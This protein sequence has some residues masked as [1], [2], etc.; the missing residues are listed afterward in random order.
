M[1][2][3]A[4]AEGGSGA[5]ELPLWGCRP[6]MGGSPDLISGPASPAGYKGDPPEQALAGS[7]CKSLAAPSESWGTKSCESGPSLPTRL[8]KGPQFHGE[9]R[10]ECPQGRPPLAVMVRGR[11]PASGRALGVPARKNQAVPDL[12]T[13]IYSAVMSI[14]RETECC[15]GEVGLSAGVRGFVVGGRSEGETIANFS[16]SF[17][18]PARSARRGGE[19][20]RRRRSE[21]EIIAKFSRGFPAPARAV[22][23][24]PGS[25]GVGGGNSVIF[26]LEGGNSRRF[27]SGVCGAPGGATG[28][29]VEGEPS[30]GGDVIVEG[31]NSRQFFPN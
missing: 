18:L 10:V 1:K 6:V 24:G 19:A 5:P 8:T 20:P 30:F 22:S 21:G 9:V 12:I 26:C 16:R 15:A 25:S 27:V 28:P 4:T 14:E 29:I 11:S 31:G 17:S 3:T 7:P 23:G 2:P 13:G